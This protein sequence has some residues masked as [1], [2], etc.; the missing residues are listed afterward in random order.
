MKSCDEVLELIAEGPVRS[1]P[2]A[3]QAEIA[4]HLAACG[5][6]ASFL[7]TQDEVAPLVRA[8]LSVDVDAA[9]QAEL[10]AAVMAAWRRRA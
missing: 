6:C 9:L 7:Q 10:D 4:E 8:A 5:A 3:A 2:A 1:L